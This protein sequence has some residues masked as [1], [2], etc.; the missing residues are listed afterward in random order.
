VFPTATQTL[1]ILLPGRSGGCQGGLARGP[2]RLL[3]RPGDPRGL[4]PLAQSGGFVR[5][6]PTELGQFCPP[7][8]RG[9]LRGRRGGWKCPLT[10][11]TEG[12][13]YRGLSRENSG[14]AG[15][16]RRRCSAVSGGH[17]SGPILFG[18]SIACD[19]ERPRR[20][21]A[22]RLLPSHFGWFNDY[23]FPGDCRASSSK[24]RPQDT[25]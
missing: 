24:E 20:G 8:R 5:N 9:Q 21:L 19:G 15:A 17:R 22:E 4:N 23:K 11:W 12:E 10:V 16:V 14:C 18:P 3:R 6:C 1:S 13:F 25:A 2:W 7:C